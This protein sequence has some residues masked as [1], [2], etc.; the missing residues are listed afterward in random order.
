[1]VYNVRDISYERDDKLFQL[2][3]LFFQPRKVS[4]VPVFIELEITFQ[5]DTSLGYVS[6]VMGRVKPTWVTHTH[7]PTNTLY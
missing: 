1:M 5:G 2:P 4:Q 6:R 7:N 3:F